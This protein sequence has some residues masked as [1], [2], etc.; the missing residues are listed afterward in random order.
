L[1]IINSI[2]KPEHVFE[3]SGSQPALI[4]CDDFDFYVCKYNRHPGSEAKKL[5]R[6]LIA[7]RFAQLWNLSVPDFCLVNVNPEHIIGHEFLQP[8]FFQTICFGS[9]Y[10]RNLAEIDEFYGEL[11]ASHK[12]KFDSKFDYLKIALFD[13]WMSNE[14]RSF[15]NYNL[16][17]DTENGNRFT[18]IDHDA[19]FNTGN[20]DKGLFLLSENET[21]IDTELAARLFSPRELR[22]MDYLTNIKN[23][24]YL[25][26]SECKKNLD[27]IL[28]DVPEDWKINAD[29][30]RTLL[31]DNSFSERWIEEVFD[32]FSELIQLKFLK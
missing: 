27:N 5:F 30:Y 14:D 8:V 6:E 10:G 26:V 18:P 15:N 24:Y 20:L 1:K 22:K 23:E 25:C 29:R 31:N 7:G 4:L 32:H 12:K 3:T 19:V 21:L 2:A 11:P 13:I 9:K 16:L 17:L 28:Q